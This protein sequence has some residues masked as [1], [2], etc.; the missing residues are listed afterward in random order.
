MQK[1]IIIDTVK[2][3]KN[4]HNKGFYKQHQVKLSDKS[5]FL[6]SG[7]YEIGVIVSTNFI[8]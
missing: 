3:T 2:H 5:D 1:V 4:M 8:N 6:T 7:F